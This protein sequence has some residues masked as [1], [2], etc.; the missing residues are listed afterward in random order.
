[1]FH[2][3]F[4]LQNRSSPIDAHR[5]AQRLDVFDGVCAKGE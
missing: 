1:M 3:Q 4:R 5:I 2:A